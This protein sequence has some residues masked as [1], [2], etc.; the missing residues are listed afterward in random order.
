MHSLTLKELT[1]HQQLPTGHTRPLC[2]HYALPTV[3]KR[4]V[5]LLPL[6]SGC[7]LTQ[8]RPLPRATCCGIP[9]PLASV[10]AIRGL[11]RSE[12]SLNV[13]DLSY[14]QDRGGAPG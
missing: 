5:A 14:A 11:A 9:V 6:P 1:W 2:S 12:S 13:V 3:L 10:S 7:E 4:L 8:A